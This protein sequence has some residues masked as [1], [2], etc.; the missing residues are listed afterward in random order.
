[1]GILCRCTAEGAEVLADVGRKLVAGEVIVRFGRILKSS[2]VD[3]GEVSSMNRSDQPLCNLEAISGD[4]DSAAR[5]YDFSNNNYDFNSRKLF[6]NNKSKSQPSTE[7]S[8]S[9]IRED[10]K[11]GGGK[12]VKFNNFVVKCTMY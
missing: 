2:H 7:G 12:F 11:I 1:M 6:G 10:S 5:K 9:G 3:V 8:C 4:L